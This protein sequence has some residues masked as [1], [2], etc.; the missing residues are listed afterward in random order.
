[1]VQSLEAEIEKLKGKGP[2]GSDDMRELTLVIGG[3]S[4]TG[5]KENAETW[6]YDKLWYAHGPKPVNVYMKGEFSGI[7]FVQFCSRA[8]REGAVHILK[9][10][11][12][13]EEGTKVWAKRDQ[14]L[15]VRI[16]NSL[17]WGTKNLLD[18]SI[19]ADPDAGIVSIGKKGEMILKG[20]VTNNVLII[21]YGVGWELYLHDPKYPEFKLMVQ[22]LQQKLNVVGTQGTGKFAR[23]T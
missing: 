11:G 19:W 14:A 4:A 22:A 6:I 2:A 20:V 9:N 12:C 10:S 15:E 18:R 7:L 23:K 3:L 21:E 8:D 1:M 13:Q 16:I 5:S 17:V